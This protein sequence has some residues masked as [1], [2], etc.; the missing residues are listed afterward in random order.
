LARGFISAEDLDL[1][2]VCDE[3]DTVIEIVQRWH[4]K[5]EVVGKKALVR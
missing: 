5:Q 4:T 1:L 2:R 3:P